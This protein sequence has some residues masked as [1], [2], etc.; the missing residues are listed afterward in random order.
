MSKARLDKL[1]TELLQH[2]NTYL[3]LHSTRLALKLTNRQIYHT[4]PALVMPTRRSVSHCEQSL[5]LHYLNPEPSRRFCRIHKLCTEPVM[6]NASP[7]R[8]QHE[9][10]AGAAWVLR[11]GFGRNGT[12]GMIDAPEGCCQEHK[13]KLV[14]DVGANLEDQGWLRSL[15]PQ[16]CS[17]DTIRSTLRTILETNTTNLSTSTRWLSIPSTVCMHCG[18]LKGQSSAWLSTSKLC[19]QCPCVT[20]RGCQSCGERDVWIYLRVVRDYQTRDQSRG[21]LF[22]RKDGRVQVREWFVEA[23]LPEWLKEV[24]EEEWD[25]RRKWGDECVGVDFEVRMLE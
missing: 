5:I 15:V 17:P 2:I 18:Q 21:Y 20:G 24:P 4:L 23:R 8:K 9:E 1:P 16:A 19:E 10:E 7:D 25:R 11:H 3:T 6:L 14:M 22:Y 13:S 12:V